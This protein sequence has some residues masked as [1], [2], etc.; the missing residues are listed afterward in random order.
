M[1]KREVFACICFA[2]VV[3]CWVAGDLFAPFPFLDGLREFIDSLGS[4]V[5]VL[6]CVCVFCFVPIDG[7]PLMN[8]NKASKTIAWQSCMMIGTVRLLGSVVNLEE[9]GIVLWIQEVFGPM[10]Q[11]M[12]TY[13]FIAVCIGAVLLLTNFVS[14]SI[15]MVLF[16]VV[17]P[18]I[19]LMPEVNGPALGVVMICAAHYAHVDPRLHHHYQLRRRQRRRGWQL[20]DAIH[21]AAHDR[22]VR[23]PALRRL[24]RRHAGVLSRSGIVNQRNI[25]PAALVTRPAALSS[26]NPEVAMDK[27]LSLGEAARGG[28]VRGALG[29]AEAVARAYGPG[30]RAVV[31]GRRYGLPEV[32]RSGSAAAKAVEFADGAEEAGAAIMRAMAAEVAEGA[33]GSATAA[34]VLAASLLSGGMRLIEAGADAAALRRGVLQ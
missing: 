33:G 21:V 26:F 17:A 15:A 31:I 13:V 1:S 10:V 9:L 3:I 29:L 25:R 4:A 14:N 23:L 34:I 6:L 24:Q 19:V 22:R 28:L 5:P 20:H 7:E 18:L 2:L 27:I 12:H 11:S 30:G 32:T 16:R 8:F